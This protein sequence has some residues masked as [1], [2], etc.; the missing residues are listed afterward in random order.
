MKLS[1]I[2]VN[3]NV[4]YFL[5]QVLLSVRTASKGLA[6]ETIVVDNNSVDGSVRMVQEQFPE[7]QLIA[8]KDNTGFAVAN[9]QAMRIAKGE[10]VLLLN[11]DTIVEED[12]F[13]QVIRFMDEHPD[14]GGLGCAMF[15]GT[16]TFLPES[17]RGLPSPWV[18]FCKM[19][20]LGALFPRSQRF[21]YYYLGHLPD[22]Q[23]HEVEVLSGAFMLM[24][25]STLDKV[26]LLD[27]T[28]FMYGEDIDLSYRITEGGYKNYYFPEA[29]IIHYKGESTK[30]GSLNYVRVFYQAMVIFAQKHFSGSGAGLY[31]LGIRLAIFL[32]AIL[33]VFTNLLR[34]LLIPMLDA[35]LVFFGMWLIKDVWETHFKADEGI[36]YSINYLLFN[37]PLYI[38][39]WLSSVFFSGGYDRPFRISRAIAGILIGTVLIGAVYGFLPNSLRYSRA[40]ILIGMLYSVFAVSALRMLINILQHQRPIVDDRARKRVVIVGGAEETV[41]V[42]ALLHET[43]VYIDLIGYV[44]IGEEGMEELSDQQAQTVKNKQLGRPDQLDEIVRIY[45]IDELIFCSKD[46]P[47]QKIIEWMVQIDGRCAFKTV[48]TDSSSIIGSNSKNT[49]GDLYTMEVSL[50]L[51]RSSSKRNKRVL[52]LISSLVLL[53]L[54]PI[55]IFVVKQPFG[56][57]RNIFQVLFGQKTWVGY[58]HEQSKKAR[59]KRLPKLKQGVLSPMD[60]LNTTTTYDEA[61]T[62]R[63]DL[64]YA[65]DHSIFSDIDIIWK[66]KHHLGRS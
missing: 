65:K 54:L 45:Q 27:E 35:L 17:K 4:Q 58:I 34:S 3:Y 37:V 6:I 46:I 14:A 2:I 16:G 51:H 56:L 10:Y 60:A 18:A 13:K 49:A 66:G 63:L 53:V 40:M 26:G 24:R 1:V 39:I 29:R 59:A 33:A 9:N 31:V 19:S 43:G 7:V 64:L 11:P 52:D 15:D 21:N 36:T 57:V 38:G 8:N 28:F 42:R 62:D 48:P 47:I 23:T 44:L 25:K 55:L 22:D 41:R 61:T 32:R 20:G 50:N 5:E 12:T 30:K